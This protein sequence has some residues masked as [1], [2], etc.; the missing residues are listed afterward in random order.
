VVERK[1]KI[2]SWCGSSV[3]VSITV[4]M[5]RREEDEKDG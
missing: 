4:I 1:G 5:R 2:V 3:V